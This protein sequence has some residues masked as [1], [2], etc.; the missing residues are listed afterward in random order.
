M[1][2]AKKIGLF[3]LTALVISSMVGSGIFSLPQNMA[4]VSGAWGIIYGW[5]IAG[6]GIIFLGLSFFFIS[7]LRPDLDGGV[8]TYAR[9]GF[10]ELVGFLSA[11]GYWA[12]ATIGTVGYVVVAFEGVGTFTDSSSNVIFG[13]GNT[14]ASFIGASIIVWLVHSLIA[15]GVKQAAIVNFIAT[16]VKISPLILFIIV[17]L[18]YFKADIFTFDMDASNL[19]TPLISQIKSTMLITL[20][21]FIGVEGASILSAHAKKKSDVGLATILGIL[22]VLSIYVLVT[23][24]SLG[25]LPQET[26]AKLSNPSMAGILEHMIGKSGKIIITLALIIS[27]LASYVSWTLYASEIP[28]QGALKGAFP[29]ILRKTNKN[30]VPIGG[31]FFTGLTVQICL[32]LV[33]A[34]GEGYVTLLLIATSMILVPYF[35]VGAYLIK[36]SFSKSTPL[37]NGFWVKATGILA[38][39]YGI[40][41]I[42]AAGL[43]TLLLSVLLYTPGLLVFLY[44]R[45]E[46]RKNGLEIKKLNPLER[47]IVILI[48][49][50]FI[51]A[52]YENAQKLFS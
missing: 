23:L 42:Y 38:T 22:I 3:T 6:G 40:W 29:K 5:I 39:L 26:I 37:K 43:D 32:I 36:L 1:D 35:L 46:E 31:L 7:R 10:G 52:L 25:I 33:L 51:Y 41:L 13:A 14:I 45:F 17:A 49:L 9:E 21:A 15:S 2:N 19:K 34:T 50:L 44:S 30:S 11:W 24:L 18:F 47:L 16:L 20:W 8:Y 48:V 28:Y 27:V 12:S 4:E